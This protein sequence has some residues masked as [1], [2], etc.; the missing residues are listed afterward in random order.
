MLLKPPLFTECVEGV[1]CEV[2]IQDSAYPRS[3]RARN[4]R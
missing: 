1:F 2:D 3:Y 4:A